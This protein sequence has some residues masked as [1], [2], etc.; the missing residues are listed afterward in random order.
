MFDKIPKSLSFPLILISG[1]RKEGY[2]GMKENTPSHKFAIDSTFEG[3]F[4]GYLWIWELTE[5]TVM[6][7]R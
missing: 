6:G 4:T 7:P 2:N 5:G 1:W 3:R